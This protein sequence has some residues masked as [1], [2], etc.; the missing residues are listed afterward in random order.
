MC[1][2][3]IL[4]FGDNQ[5]KL[6]CGCYILS[7]S[8]ILMG[9]CMFYI[10]SG[11]LL[12]EATFIMITVAVSDTSFNFILCF[13][14]LSIYILAVICITLVDYCHFNLKYSGLIV[15]ESSKSICG[16]MQHA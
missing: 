16:I 15:K 1:I 2:I 4:L 7:S 12:K 8:E 5:E 9:Q 11:S 3:A 6:L 14:Y 10:L 13:S